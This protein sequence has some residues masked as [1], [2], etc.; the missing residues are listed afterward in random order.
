MLSYYSVKPECKYLEVFI[1]LSD[2]INHVILPKYL[3]ELGV[4]ELPYGLIDPISK[5]IEE[6]SANIDT[7]ISAGVSA[8][9]L[10]PIGE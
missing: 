8:F 10:S 2:F 5:Q 9:M 4:E 6:I 1:F 3:F 7:A